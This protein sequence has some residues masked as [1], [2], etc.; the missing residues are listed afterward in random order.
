MNYDWSWTIFLDLSSNGIDT[1]LYNLLTGV[2]WTLA[3]SLSAGL[4]SLILG[5]IV[6]VL[7]TAPSM[8]LH[9]IGTVYVEIFRNIPL[10][11]QMFL[12]YFVLPELLPKDWG[13]ALKQMGQPWGQFIPAVLCLSFYGTARLAETLRAGIQSLP[14]GQ[15]QAGT[16]MG[17]TTAQVY[18]YVIMPQAYRIVIAP[19]TSE[20]MGIVKYS[21]VALTI[22]L[23]ELTGQARAMQEFSFH[24]FEAFSAA[25]VGY[26]VI[27]GCVVLVMHYLEQHFALP[28]RI[29]W[30]ARMK[31]SGSAS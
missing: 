19:L 11:V 23:L 16:A 5:S 26:L 22:G 12:W 21:S 28:G 18:R 9:F 14:R 30:K 17:L 25:T 6:A 15:G 1:Y 4:A 2:G 24:I 10:L 29:G 8:V 20:F 3:L 7:R 13:D 27:N 31:L